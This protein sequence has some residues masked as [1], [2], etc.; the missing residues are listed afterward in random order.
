MQP[1]EGPWLDVIVHGQA[2]CPPILLQKLPGENG[3]IERIPRSGQ[4]SS[5][6][7]TACDSPDRS[8]STD[9]ESAQLFME[10]I[11]SES[12]MPNN[13]EVFDMEACDAQVS[14][15]VS[16]MHTLEERYFV[17]D[18][19][20]QGSR[21]TIWRCTQRESGQIR[22]VKRTRISEMSITDVTREVQIM[23]FL[24]NDC[25]IRCHEVFFGAAYVDVVLDMLD[26][27]N[28]MDA[29]RSYRR[30]Y[31]RLDDETLALVSAQTLKAIVHLHSLDIA[32]RDIKGGHFL[33]ETYFLND[34]HCR[35]ALSDFSTAIANQEGHLL[36]EEVGTNS[37]WAPEVWKH[38]YDRRADIW[39]LGITILTLLTDLPP[40]S[41]KDINSMGNHSW[42]NSQLQRT[43]CQ[44]SATSKCAE[45]VEACLTPDLD[46]RPRASELSCHSWLMMAGEF[47]PSE[48]LKPSSVF[49]STTV[50]CLGFCWSGICRD[51]VQLCVDR[52]A[53]PNHFFDRQTSLT[54]WYKESSP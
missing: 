9:S 50:S 21:C 4:S 44:V 53:M 32:H 31:T 22:A 13:V 17:G 24:E 41:A 33:C 54:A 11:N 15:Q 29:L 14:I 47:K 48:N 38:A 23:N 6:S 8:C 51:F 1:P 30:A 46:H 12:L 28:L 40:F 10:R 36:T 25:I 27:G 35:I 37:F 19:V 5:T 7:S 26:G 16:D 43:L 20:V 42:Q 39:A 49:T 34:T 18:C 2:L 45:F 52:L 3:V